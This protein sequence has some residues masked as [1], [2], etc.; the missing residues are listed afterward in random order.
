MTHTKCIDRATTTGNQANDAEDD[1]A[2]TIRMYQSQPA[3][4]DETILHIQTTEEEA[5][6]R[7]SYGFADANDLGVQQRT[8]LGE[9]SA[10]NLLNSSIFI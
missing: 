3:N 10:C 2:L 4:T 8:E 9:G 1:Y 7:G 6:K 5:V